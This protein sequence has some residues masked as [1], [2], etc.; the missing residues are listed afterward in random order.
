MS[1]SRTPAFGKDSQRH[2]MAQRFAGAVQAAQRG[3]GVA[4]LN[5]NLARARKVPPHER[6]AEQLALGH[7]AELPRNARVQH[8]NVECRQMIGRVNRS[9]RRI[10]VLAAFDMHVNASG[11][12]DHPRPMHREPVLHASATIEE[13]RQQRQ[14]PHDRGVEVNQRNEDEIRSQATEQSAF[15]VRR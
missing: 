8:G 4:L 12:Q 6:I 5:R 9:L 15:R 2:S 7:D 3:A 10:N 1:V 14:A 11:S 13:R